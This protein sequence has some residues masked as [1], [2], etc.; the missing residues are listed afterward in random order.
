MARLTTDPNDPEIQ[1]GADTEPGPQNKAYLVAE[2]LEPPYIRPLRDSYVHVGLQPPKNLRLLTPEELERWGEYNYVAYEEY[3]DPESA[4]QGR[5]WTQERLDMVNDGCGTTTVMNGDR[6]VKTWAKYPNFYGGTYCLGC[7]KH[8]PCEEFVWAGTDEVLG[9]GPS[10]QPMFPPEMGVEENLDKDN[11]EPQEQT[12]VEE[13]AVVHT[14]AN[15]NRPVSN[16]FTILVVLG[17]VAAAAAAVFV[18][19]PEALLQVKAILGL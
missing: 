7:K 6:L 4:F 15:K 11:L 8:L 1:R 17:L 12:P 3:G 16:T 13:P 9:S 19:Y 14:T 10:D 2:D 18:R 5:F